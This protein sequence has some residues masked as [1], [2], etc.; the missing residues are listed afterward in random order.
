V[1]AQQPFDSP[2]FNGINPYTLGY[3]MMQDI[4][5]ICENPTDE[6]REWFPEFAGS[7]WQE[8]LNDAMRNYKDESFILQFLSPK[9]IRQLKLFTI[10]DNSSKPTLS[11]TSIHN[12][13]G[14]RQ[15]R[16][17]LAANYNLGN[18]EPNIQVYNVDV[19]G[20]RSLTLR[21]YMH[22]QQPLGASTSEVLRHIHR[23]WGFDVHLES[24][25]P[26]NTLSKSFHCPEITAEGETASLL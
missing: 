26:D 7:N 12:E 9:L 14:Y 19:R 1:V 22:N 3:Y 10:L 18:R 4:R 8:T 17:D 15:I 24:V 13:N 5:R 25:M 20:D 21:H 11:V 16:E 6:D 2:Y 23:L